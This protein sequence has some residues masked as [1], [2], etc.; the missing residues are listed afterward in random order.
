MRNKAMFKNVS[1]DVPFS[2]ST[3]ED[4]VEKFTA[5]VVA[6]VTVMDNMT[7]EQIVELAARPRIITFQNANRPKGADHLRKLDGSTIDIVLFPIHAHADAVPS[8][9]KA[10]DVLVKA[11]KDGKMTEEQALDEVRKRMTS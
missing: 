3:K 1:V 6:H 2:V 7:V 4:S 9:D 8:T 5:K 10:I 11:V